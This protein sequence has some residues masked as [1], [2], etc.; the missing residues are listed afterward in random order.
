MYRLSVFFCQLYGLRWSVSWVILVWLLKGFC[1]Q[2]KVKAS[3][4]KRPPFLFPQYLVTWAIRVWEH[5][6]W[7]DDVKSG[8][9]V[10]G[11][12]VLEWDD[13]DFVVWGQM[14]THPFNSHVICNLHKQ[15]HTAGLKNLMLIYAHSVHCI[16]GETCKSMSNNQTVALSDKAADHKANK[17]HNLKNLCTWLLWTKISFPARMKSAASKQGSYSVVTNFPWEASLCLSSTVRMG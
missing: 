11:V 17:L 8:I 10:H 12:R 4:H 6:S 1:L 3:A 14:A 5:Q 16:Q 9:D 2:T 13:V 7:S 15:S